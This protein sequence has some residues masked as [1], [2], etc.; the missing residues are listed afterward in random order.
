MSDLMAR[1]SE[2]VGP[3]PVIGWIG[4]GG[5]GLAVLAARGR[6]SAAPA[7]G[8]GTVT[9]APGDTT[10]GVTPTADQTIAGIL[11]AL[12][13]LGATGATISLPGG[14]SLD[15]PGFTSPPGGGDLPPNP[16]PTPTPSPT[17]S[18]IINAGGVDTTGTIVSPPGAGGG[19]TSSTSGGGA[20]NSPI[21]GSTGPMAPFRLGPGPADALINPH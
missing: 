16:A 18:P 8:G 1:L 7:G 20:T 9:L 3:L 15:V 11:A 12:K 17:P 19:G 2:K 5:I 13:N 14:A 4:I 6:S 10:N 21:I